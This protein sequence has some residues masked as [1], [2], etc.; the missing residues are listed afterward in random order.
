M[1]GLPILEVAIGL[2]FVYLLLALICTAANETIAAITERRASFLEKGIYSLLG[3]DSDLTTKVLEHPLV[4][5][6]A[7]KKDATP[8]YLPASKFAL[9][10]MDV[11]PGKG[12]EVDSAQPLRAGIKTVNATSHRN[13]LCRQTVF[14]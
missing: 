6:L 3:D 10:L 13:P 8:S 2:T 5:S 9:A 7:P 11:L 12:K 14:N 1:F 4:A